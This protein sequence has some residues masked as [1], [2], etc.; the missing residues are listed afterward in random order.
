MMLKNE[1]G[2]S[3][4]QLAYLKQNEKHFTQGERV[5][6]LQLPKSPLVQKK[7]PLSKEMRE[8]PLNKPIKK[9]NE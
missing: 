2:L 7:K 6:T 3:P 1:E 5:V 4:Q 9:K 8:P